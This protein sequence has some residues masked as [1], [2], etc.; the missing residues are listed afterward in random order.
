MFVSYAFL[1]QMS[2]LSH[3]VTVRDIAIVGI[4]VVSII[5]ALF[6]VIAAWIL[7]DT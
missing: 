2:Y 7:R 4:C 3:P 6:N 5:T 1:I